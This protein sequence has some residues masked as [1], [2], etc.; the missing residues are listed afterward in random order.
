MIAASPPPSASVK[1]RRLI[2][3]LLN[4]KAWVNLPGFVTIENKTRLIRN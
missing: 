1:M 3:H 4:P 2:L